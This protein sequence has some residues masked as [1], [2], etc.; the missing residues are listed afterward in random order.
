MS[1]SSITTTSRGKAHQKVLAIGAP[2]TGNP[3]AKNIR[4]K[5][6]MREGGGKKNGG[7]KII[8]KNTCRGF[9]RIGKRRIQRQGPVS[10]KKLVRKREILLHVNSRYLTVE[11][12]K[13]L[14][15]PTIVG[16][17]GGGRGGSH[18]GEGR[19]GGVSRKGPSE[20]KLSATKGRG[21]EVGM[22]WNEQGEIALRENRLRGGETDL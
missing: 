13:R 1:W 9:E 21:G 19:V 4:S 17:K 16:G 22:P 6:K 15:I 10:S 8:V 7:R 18:L 14:I 2:P 11:R 5:L 20:L 12:R 3:L